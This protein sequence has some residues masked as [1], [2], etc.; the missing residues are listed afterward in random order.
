[1]RTSGKIVIVAI[2]ALIALPL[3][4]GGEKCTASAQ[5]CLD[6]M[7]QKMEHKGWVGIEGEKLDSG[8][9]E[10]AKVVPDSP[11]EAAGL[12][13]G[14]VLVGVNGIDYADTDKEKWKP[15]KAAWKP[16][17]SVTYTVKRSGHK[18]ESALTLGSAPEEVVAQ[19]I[20]KH[21]MHDHSTVA[22]A[23]K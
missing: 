1:M 22:V 5:D 11:A 9:F 19:W 10:I 7:V 4:A 2:A 16:G 6:K 8:Y 18:K 15:V 12:K 23:K 3:F 13:P 17:N 14:D 21:M 20:G